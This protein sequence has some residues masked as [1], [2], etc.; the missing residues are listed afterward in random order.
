[1]TRGDPDSPKGPFVRVGDSNRWTINFRHPAAPWVVIAIVL[2][3]VV[4]L[5]LGF[6]KPR[7]SGWSPT[8]AQAQSSQAGR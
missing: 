7:L 2:L 4:G 5:K 6:F 8:P 1:M 3:A